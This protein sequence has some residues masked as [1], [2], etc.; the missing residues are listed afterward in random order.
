M[1]VRASSSAMSYSKCGLCLKDLEVINPASGIPYIRC[2]DWKLCPFFCREDSIHGYQQCLR[3]R[4]IPDYKVHEG[5]QLPYCI[6]M[7]VATL[8]VSRSQKNPFRPYFTCRRKE[9]CRFFRWA[10][11]LP[12]DVFQTQSPTYCPEEK[13][14]LQVDMLQRLQRPKLQRQVDTH[15]CLQRHQLQR[16]FGRIDSPKW[17]IDSEH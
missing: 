1:F 9:M 3:D 7:D 2:V 16:Q 6:H 4:V 11:E 10:D 13:V 12:V 15:R 17:E 8:K 5:G 14:S